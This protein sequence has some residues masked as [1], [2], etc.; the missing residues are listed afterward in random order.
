MLS[1]RSGIIGLVGVGMALFERCVTVE[2]GFE[3]SS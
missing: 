3:T 1:P 2:V